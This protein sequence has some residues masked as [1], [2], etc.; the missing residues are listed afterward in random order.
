MN[1]YDKYF[2]LTF[3][4]ILITRVVVATFFMLHNKGNTIPYYSEDFSGYA[5]GLAH[6]TINTMTSHSI[7]SYLL[8]KFLILLL[9]LIVKI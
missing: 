8:K 2:L 5:T 7:F 4:T 3:I 1:L 9:L 6:K